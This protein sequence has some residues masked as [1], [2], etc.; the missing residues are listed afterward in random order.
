MLKFRKIVKWQLPK[1]RTHDLATGTIVTVVGYFDVSMKLD[2][3][4]SPHVKT[5]VL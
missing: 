2:E 3:I 4:V 1:K 5:G